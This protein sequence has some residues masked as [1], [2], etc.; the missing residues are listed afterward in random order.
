[1]VRGRASRPAGRP[2]RRAAARHRDR[3]RVG[4]R[5]RANA[6]EGRERRQR[7]QHGEC[8]EV[9]D[10]DGFGLWHVSVIFGVL[11]LCRFGRDRQP[12]VVGLPRANREG[13]G[14]PHTSGRRPDPD[15]RTT[16]GQVGTRSGH[17]R[18]RGTIRPGPRPA[19]DRMSDRRNADGA[20]RPR[21][22]DVAH[23]TQSRLAGVFHRRR[24]GHGRRDRVARLPGGQRRR[25]AGGSELVVRDVVL[26]RS[27]V[28]GGGGGAGRPIV[29]TPPRRLL[30]DRRRL[31]GRDRDLQRV[32][33]LR[34]DRGS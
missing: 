22:E 16:T 24:R 21:V 13:P 33:P 5:R 32:P 14:V 2:G 15:L 12:G 29:T 20:V 8:H 6:G 11:S 9:A 3:D 18:D 30:P 26:R 28:L 1:M 7:R 25:G 34:L 10:E 23:R 27:R 17:D 31:G 19:Y 4:R